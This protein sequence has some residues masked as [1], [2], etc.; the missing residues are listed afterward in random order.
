MPHASS[1][2]HLP[3]LILR[4]VDRPVS[5]RAGEQAGE[6]GCDEDPLNY[7]VSNV[8]SVRSYHQP[9]FLQGD[10]SDFPATGPTD[11]R[12]SRLQIS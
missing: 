12:C 10:M 6:L 2:R 8:L 7:R 3:P 4:H 1:T 11:L 9:V 5:T